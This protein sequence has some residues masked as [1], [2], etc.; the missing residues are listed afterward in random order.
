MCRERDGTALGLG[1]GQIGTK[2]ALWDVNEEQI[3]FLASETCLPDY[4]ASRRMSRDV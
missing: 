4:T 2:H 1:L 3:H